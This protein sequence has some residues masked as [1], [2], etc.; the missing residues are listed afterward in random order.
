MLAATRKASAAAEGGE[1]C[2][3]GAILK[4]VNG[5]EAALSEAVKAAD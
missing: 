3:A 5:G 2:E 1:C 4:R